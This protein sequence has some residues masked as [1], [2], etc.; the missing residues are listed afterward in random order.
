VT[1]F[2]MPA[3]MPGYYQLLD[4]EKKV[5]HFH[6]V[7][8]KGQELGWEKTTANTWRVAHPPAA[9]VRV[10]YDVVADRNFVAQPWLDSTR[11]YI[12]PAG[13]FLYAEGGLRWPVV[14]EVR[15]LPG[16][17][18]STGLELVKG[19]AST[20]RAADFDIL[21]DRP[22]LMGDLEQLPSF[23]VRGIPHYFVGYRM[24]E[25]DRGQFIAGLEKVVTAGVDL[26]GGSG[27]WR[28]APSITSG[29]TGRT[30]CGYPKG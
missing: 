29:R 8:G 6:A 17:K 18:V 27:R 28:W 11:G 19:E 23:M 16:W 12:A 9:E 14:V 21:Y 30:S 20:Y 4:Y 1:D 22:I 15:P 13:I 7:D 26:I 5:A 24:G 25:F 10:E 2:S 3:W